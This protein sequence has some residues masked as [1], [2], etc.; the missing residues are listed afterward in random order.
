MHRCVQR[1]SAAASAHTEIASRL[2]GPGAPGG[3]TETPS[4]GETIETEGQRLV[5]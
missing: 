3:W 5:G 2:Y 4:G 1:N